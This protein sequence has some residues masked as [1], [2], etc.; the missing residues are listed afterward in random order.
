[1][2]KCST[3]ERIKRKEL[4][5]ETEA[6]RG[7]RLINKHKNKQII[8]NVRNESGEITSDREEILLKKNMRRFLQI[9]LYQNS[10]HTGK[11]NEIKS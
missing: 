7:P 1:M 2:K 5:Q 3:R 9:T 4:I 6:R 8:M 10:A 11:Y